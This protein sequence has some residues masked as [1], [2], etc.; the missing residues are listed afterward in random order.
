MMFVAMGVCTFI[1]VNF[2]GLHVFA[3]RQYSHRLEGEVASE[4]SL[5]LA[6]FGLLFIAISPIATWLT[7]KNAAKANEL[8]IVE[9]DGMPTE[10]D[11]RIGIG[12]ALLL[13]AVGLAGLWFSASVM[14]GVVASLA[15]GAFTIFS[16]Y[17]LL[18]FMFSAGRR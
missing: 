11:R 13:C 14:R 10:A 12:S 5:F 18:R 17:F 2:F 15:T 1:G 6:A 4:G 8:A 7:R 3:G 16:L 9:R